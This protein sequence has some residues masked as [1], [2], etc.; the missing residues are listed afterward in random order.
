MKDNLLGLQKAYDKSPEKA[1]SQMALRIPQRS[2]LTGGIVTDQAI[3]RQKMY[4]KSL[5]NDID[6]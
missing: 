5:K 3:K 2:S 4:L 6:I 1:M